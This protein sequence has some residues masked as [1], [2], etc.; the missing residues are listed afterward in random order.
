MQEV[1]I[2]EEGRVACPRCGYDLDADSGD[3]IRCENCDEK[4]VAVSRKD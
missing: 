1:E 4:F 3:E 2:N